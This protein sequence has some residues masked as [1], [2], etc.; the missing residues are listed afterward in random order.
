MKKLLVGLLLL[1]VAAGLAPAAAAPPDPCA[2][3]PRPRPRP[4]KRRPPAPRPPE[5]PPKKCDCPPGERGPAGERGERGETG[6]RGPAGETW[7]TDV[8]VVERDPLLRLGLGVAGFAAAPHGDWAWGPALRLSTDA[9]EKYELGLSVA[10]AAGA[11]SGR[12]SGV[13]VELTATRWLEPAEAA[14]PRMG[15]SAGFLYAGLRGSPSNGEIDGSYLG[16]TAGAVLQ[17][18]HVRAQ[19]GP[20]VGGLRDDAEPGTQLFVGFAGSAFVGGAW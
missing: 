14:T 4:P 7:V 6:E 3:A 20:V 11:S 19:L 15:L 18:R 13:L 10:A 17:W 16:V 5:A 1:S 12:E 9:S 2:E 8:I